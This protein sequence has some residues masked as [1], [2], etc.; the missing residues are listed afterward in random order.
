M[1]TAP[2]RIFYDLLLIAFFFGAGKE[3]AAEEDAEVEEEEEEDGGVDEGKPRSSFMELSEKRFL[4][5]QPDAVV[6]AAEKAALGKERRK[7]GCVPF[8][9]A[10]CAHLLLILPNSLRS[11][12]LCAL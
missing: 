4:L 12:R 1:A 6:P 10:R 9:Y 2:R 5:Q 7:S 8:F 11:L 3:G